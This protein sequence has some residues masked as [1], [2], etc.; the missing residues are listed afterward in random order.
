MEILDY[1]EK[2]NAAAS[3]DEALVLFR[4][5]VG[6][7]GFDRVMYHSTRAMA[8]GDEDSSSVVLTNY[9]NEWLGHYASKRWDKFDP[10]VRYGIVAPRP[11]CWDALPTQMHMTKQQQHLMGAAGDAGLMDGVGIPLHGPRGESSGVGLAS[12][13]GQT[14]AARHLSV[15]NALVHQFHLNY[16]SFE[17]PGSAEEVAVSLTAREREVLHWC[18]QGKSN[19]TIGEIIGISEH[20]VEFHVRNILKKLDVDSRITA[21]VRALH[22]GLIVP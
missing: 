19:W 1:I 16:W 6:Q 9:P 3:R 13:T 21:V 14:D 10:V 18:A 2:S 15:L 7:Y 11:F 17:E 12:S 4:Q 5:A 22:M 8:E 20:G